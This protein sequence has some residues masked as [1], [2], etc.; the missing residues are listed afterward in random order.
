MKMNQFQR[1]QLLEL[2]DT[3]AAEADVRREQ[4]DKILEAVKQADMPVITSDIA[5]PSPASNKRRPRRPIAELNV[6]ESFFMPGADARQ[7]LSGDRARQ[8]HKL[9]GKEF[10]VRKATEG[11]IHGARIWRIE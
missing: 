11:G 10:T 2:F 9:N 3:L 5:A 7:L 6:G 1:Q 8:R 4:M